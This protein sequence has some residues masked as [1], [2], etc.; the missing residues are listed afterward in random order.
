MGSR[1]SPDQWVTALQNNYWIFILLTWRQRSLN[2]SGMMATGHYDTNTIIIIVISSTTTTSVPTA[3][4]VTQVSIK[5]IISPL[6]GLSGAIIYDV[7]H[8]VS[9]VAIWTHS[10][11]V[12]HIST[13]SAQ[14]SHYLNHCLIIVDNHWTICN[15]FHIL[16]VQIMAC[17]LFSTSA[18]LLLIVTELCA[19]L[20]IY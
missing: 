13:S 19:M 15:A 2:I 18:G 20:L 9:K 17:H 8:Y 5:G 10:N 11:W 12:M 16:K 7:S 4:Q 3:S 1:P 6:S 14:R